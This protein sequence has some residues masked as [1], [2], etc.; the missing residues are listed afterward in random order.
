MIVPDEVILVL[1]LWIFLSIFTKTYLIRRFGLNNLLACLILAI[2]FVGTLIIA[3]AVLSFLFLYASVVA[4]IVA[5]WILFL[6]ARSFIDTDDWR[7]RENV[8]FAS[9]A[10]TYLAFYILT[11]IINAISSA[12]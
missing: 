7:T 3:L 10:V 1:L 12:L 4:V 11:I 5:T 6:A 8:L 2:I 9:V